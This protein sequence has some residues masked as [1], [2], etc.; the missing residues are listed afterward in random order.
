LGGKQL[1]DNIMEQDLNHF[2]KGLFFPEYGRKT[3]YLFG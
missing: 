1:T 2:S 3:L